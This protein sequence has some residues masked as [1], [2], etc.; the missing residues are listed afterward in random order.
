G[1][2]LH[3]A[4]VGEPGGAREA[5]AQGLRSARQLARLDSRFEPL[6]ERLAGLEAELTDVADEARGLV[7]C[8]DHD[9]AEPAGVEERLSLIYALE[10]RYGDDEDAVIA[11]GQR[12][13]AEV[14]RLS[15]MEVERERR[16]AEDARLLADVAGAAA[17]LSDRRRVTA[18][19]L[20]GLVSHA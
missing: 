9:P 7:D 19:R 15:T 8:V 12:A 20:G 13:A 18:E 10:R 14:V 11:Y 6:T 5:V 16:A 4:L 2:E 17:A 3:E 1:S